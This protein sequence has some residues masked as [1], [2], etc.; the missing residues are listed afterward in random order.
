MQVRIKVTSKPSKGNHFDLKSE[1]NFIAFSGKFECCYHLIV[2]LKIN[3]TATTATTIV[4][5]VVI[6][7]KAKLE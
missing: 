5:S 7:Q 4:Y 6:G 3:T 2:S 1:L